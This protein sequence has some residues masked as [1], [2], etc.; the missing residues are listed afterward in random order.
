MRRSPLFE[1]R[2]QVVLV[3]I[4]ALAGCDKD[5][6]EDPEET[7]SAPDMS[8]AGASMVGN[9][10]SGSMPGMDTAPEQ[11]PDP[12][13]Q[14]QAMGDQ[15]LSKADAR[16]KSKWVYLDLD[17]RRY[18]AADAQEQG[19]WDIAF[20]RVKIKVNGGVSGPGP[21]KALAVDGPM[22]YEMLSVAPKEGY[23]MDKESP[24]GPDEDPFKE[25]GMVFGRWYE[26]DLQTHVVTPK[27]R[28]FVVQ[29]DQ[30]RFFKIKVLD[31]YNEAKTSGHY[32][33]QWSEIPAG[34]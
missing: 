11:S 9:T 30:N 27:A 13:V 6:I 29:T 26:Y 21:V 10:G 3:T 32:S 25:H 23:E 18:P 12:Q 16:S 17:D 4:F 34:R 24:D 2:F 33:F 7:S 8:S 1:H 20:Q 22:A 31:Y 19:V 5:L 14:H 15:W 28:A